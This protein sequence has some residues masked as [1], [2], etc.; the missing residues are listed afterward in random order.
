MKRIL[1]FLAILWFV[2]GPP[3]CFALDWKALHEQA[4]SIDLATAIRHAEEDPPSLEAYYV[5]GLVYLGLYR[6]E[7]AEM[8]FDRLLALVPEI[9]EGLW[10]KAE[11]LRRHHR[12]AE[13]EA[14]LERLISEYPGYYP[15]YLTLAYIRFIQLRF[16]DSAD[17]V[18]KIMRRH[19]ADIDVT[20]YARAHV[21]FAGAKGM[22]ARS[23][24]PV[25]RL[26]NGFVVMPALREAQSMTP[27]RP[28]VLYG[29]G[30]YY[31]LAPRG[32][33]KNIRLA[34]EYFDRMIVKAP[35]FPDG[36]VRLA[37]V[38]K[39]MGDESKYEQLLDTA[40]KLDPQSELALDIKNKT[41]L[42]VCPDNTSD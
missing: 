32:L 3:P 20:N 16:R 29:F 14:I 30:S 10:G 38:Y 25:S 28:E 24:D 15:S 2:F 13:S 34:K 11:V 8:S 21:L 4:D 17:L 36:Y 18:L 39:I 23:G 41:C 26:I 7:D 6:T 40:L 31:L 9:K 35:F 19:R 37:Q 22:I 1:L 5:L 27:D 12:V 33:G 42:F